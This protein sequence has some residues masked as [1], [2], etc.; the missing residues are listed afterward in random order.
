MTCTSSGAQ[1][2]GSGRNPGYARR[3]NLSPSVI[4]RIKVSTSSDPICMT[5]EPVNTNFAGHRDM[6]SRDKKG[7]REHERKRPDSRRAESSREEKLAHPQ[8]QSPL[9][10]L[11]LAP[12]T[13]ACSRDLCSP[14]RCGGVL[15][16]KGAVATERRVRIVVVILATV[17]ARTTTAA[18]S[19]RRGIFLYCCKDFSQLANLPESQDWYNS[20]AS[21]GL[22]LIRLVECPSVASAIRGS[23]SRSCCTSGC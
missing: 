10:R 2:S 8:S 18:A 4:V 22:P 13:K 17:A 9:S 21:E 20:Q 23:S 12:G 16:V 6:M 15:A 1:L 14:A 11:V 7:E 19:E 5:G 3:E